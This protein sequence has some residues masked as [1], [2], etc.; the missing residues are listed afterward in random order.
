[1]IRNADD[2]GSSAEVNGAIAEAFARGLVTSTSLMA[3]ASGF[4]EACALVRERS[5]GDLGV[6]LVLTEG[7]PLTEPIRR[8]RRFCGA[9]GTFFEWRGRGTR[10]RV[11]RAEGDAL[12][13]ELRAQVR[14]CC[15]AGVEIGHLDSHHHVHTEWAI[16]EIVVA[17]ARELAIPRVRLARNCG[18]GIGVVVHAYKRLFNAR[19]RRAGVAGTR[20]FGNVDDWHHLRAAGA[21]RTAL[22][23][24]ELMVHPVRTP[25]G[26]LVDL[27]AP[28]R[29]LE[30]LLQPLLRR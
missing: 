16:G 30:D 6:H 27:E 24:F 28:E 19:L 25:D 10:F 22:E 2:F 3:T 23:D 13:R 7:V 21:P 8:C 20:Y 18:A 29:L 9:D 26:A 12:A 5:V 11:S 14:R 17:L 1:V 15:D 4:E